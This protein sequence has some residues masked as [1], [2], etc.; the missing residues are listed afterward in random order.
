MTRADR[1][2][3]CLYGAAI[4]DALG[5]AFEFV[6]SGT[7][8][9]SLGEPVVREYHSALSGS[10]LCPRDPGLPTDDTAMALSVACAVASGAPLT[11]NLFARRFLEDLDRHDGRF[12]T[13]FWGGG[14]GGATTCALS[15]LR[16]GAESEN[17]GHPE[18]GGNGAAMRAHPIGFL[19]DRA[20]VLEVAAKQARVTHGHPAAIAAAVAVAVTVYDAL[21]GVAPSTDVPA[22]ISDLTFAKTW[23]ELHRDLAPSGL[24]LPSR[25]R[26]VAMSGWETVA[27]AH[28][29]AMCFA[30]DPVVAI[31]VAAASGGDTDTLASITGA[32]VGARAGS[33]AFPKSWVE[34]LTARELI[35]EVLQEVLS[36]PGC[37]VT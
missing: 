19:A 17:C 4:G 36:S 18:D 35:D 27:A 34:G 33:A 16:R 22:G 12:G 11:A 20:M 2:A 37:A 15:R 31:G 28:A 3:G 23:R 7:I 5:S 9:R 32:I 30:G 14:P 6:D 24:R 10:L 13:M 25:L 1:I 29:I 21:H 26:N 8:E